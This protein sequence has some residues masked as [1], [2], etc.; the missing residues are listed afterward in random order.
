MIRFLLAILLLSLSSC[1]LFNQEQKP[2]SVARVGKSYLYKSDLLNLVPA[3]TSKQDSI[4]MVQSY[5]DRWATQKLLIEAAE[6]NL[7]ESKQ[8]EYNALIKQY[9]I[10]LYTKAYL[11]EMVKQTVDTIVSEEELKKYYKENKANFKANGT[12]VRMRYITIDKDNPKLATIRDKLF[13][14][15]KKDKKFWDTYSL[16]FK[17]FAF[18]DSVWVG[19]EQVYSKLPVVNPENRD[20]IIRAGKKLQILDNQDLYLIKVTDVIDEK[21]ASPFGYIKPTLKEVIVNQRK[22]ELI[23]KIEKEIT[24]DA[25]KNKDYEIYK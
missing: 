16:Q 12:L 13:N 19:M 14:F 22:L 11:E 6:R 15:N 20:E 9:K 10:D 18:N 17:K 24:D 2:E 21:Q 1:Q 5:I 4:L 7:S 3:G 25:I 23:K 8:K